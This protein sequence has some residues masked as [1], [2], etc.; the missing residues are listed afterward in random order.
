MENVPV[1][2]TAASPFR[3]DTGTNLNRASDPAMSKRGLPAVS[4]KFDVNAAFSPT[5]SIRACV[6]FS[7]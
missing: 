4:T 3:W 7:E 6:S 2:Q 1:G 5:N